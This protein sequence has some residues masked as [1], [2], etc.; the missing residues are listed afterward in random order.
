MRCCR[1][2]VRE[3]RGEQ[4][5]QT[6]IGE[7]ALE[8]HETHAL[9]DDVAPGISQDLFLDPIAAVGGSVLNPVCRNAGRDLEVSDR[10]SRFSS[11]K[12]VRPSVT[13]KPRSRVHA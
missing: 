10:V 2:P 5:V 9:E 13:M 11:E 7:R 4:D 3:V 12:Y 1:R 8:R 6:E